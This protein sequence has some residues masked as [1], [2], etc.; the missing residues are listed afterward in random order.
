MRYSDKYKNFPQL[1]G[2]MDD[3]SSSDEHAMVIDE[4]PQH[5]S[6]PSASKTIQQ[7]LNE[8]PTAYYDSEDDG[9]SFHPKSPFSP[10]AVQL[11]EKSK[12]GSRQSVFEFTAATAKK[13]G[14]KKSSKMPC[15][16]LNAT[17]DSLGSESGAGCCMYWNDTQRSY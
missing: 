5:D 16:K 6:E 14:K 13:G 17:F 1:D 8:T 11:L 15:P 9:L 3:G 2:I 7:C 10:R 12:S 4:N